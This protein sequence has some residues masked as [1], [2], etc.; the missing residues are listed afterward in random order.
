MR[1]QDQSGREVFLGGPVG[2]RVLS[3]MASVR[4]AVG[5]NGVDLG[6]IDAGR[7]V[8]RDANPESGPLL[9]GLFRVRGAGSGCQAL[10]PGR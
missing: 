2:Q 3:V 10:A 9:R 8:Q 5:A 6:E 1:S 4:D 7:V